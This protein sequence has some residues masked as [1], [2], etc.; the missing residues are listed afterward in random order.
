L[1]AALLI[2]LFYDFSLNSPSSAFG[3][4]SSHFVARLVIFLAIAVVVLLIIHRLQQYAA[5]LEAKERALR[6][7]RQA[8]ESEHLLRRTAELHY[9]RET[10]RFETVLSGILDAVVSVDCEGI[11]RYVNAAASEFSGLKVEDC[12]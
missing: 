12:L 6:L 10:I 3:V 7:S 1:V 8:E 11:V 5:S 9:A 4:W 2:G